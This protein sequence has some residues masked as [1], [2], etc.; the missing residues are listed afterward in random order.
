M[1]AWLHLTTA[2]QL[3][4]PALRVLSLCNQPS[5]RNCAC[6]ARAQISIWWSMFIESLDERN[7]IA[8]NCFQFDDR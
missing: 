8:Q 7:L 1:L 6:N 5:C 4:K 2:N 3:I